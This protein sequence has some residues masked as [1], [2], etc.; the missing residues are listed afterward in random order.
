MLSRRNLRV[1][2]MQVLF[3]M[4]HS[5]PITAEEAVRILDRN[6]EKSH[7]LLAF[8]FSLIVR[9]A[10]FIQRGSEFKTTKLLPTEDDLHFSTKLVGNPFISAL[11]GNKKIGGQLKLFMGEEE[12]LLVKS[13][14]KKLAEQ[15]EYKLYCAKKETSLKDEREIIL[16]LYSKVIIKNPAYL[17]YAE[18]NFPECINELGKIHFTV[19][20]SLEKLSPESAESLLEFPDNQAEENFAKEL[21]EKTLTNNDRFTEQIQPKLKNWDVDRI[22]RMDMILMKMALCELLCFEQIP[23]KVSINEYIDISKVFS[24]PRSKDFINGILDTVMHDL[25]E[26]NEIKK[27]GRGLVE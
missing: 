9:V 7:R 23:V 20:E 25:R 16:F 12:D 6:I 22:A 5:N 4:D 11:R 27:T 3:S 21:L 26:R 10:D 17:L 18:D 2:V 8:N 1:K 14:F 13:I 24:T 15:N 19:S